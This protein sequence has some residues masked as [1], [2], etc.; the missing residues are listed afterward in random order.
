MSTYFYQELSNVFFECD[1]DKT[2][3]DIILTIKDYWNMLLDKCIKCEAF[4]KSY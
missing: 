2:I 1:V 3:L 4:N